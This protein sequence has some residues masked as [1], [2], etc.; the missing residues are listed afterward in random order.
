MNRFHSNETSYLPSVYPYRCVN[1]H[2]SIL[3]YGYLISYFFNC[4]RIEMCI[5]FCMWDERHLF[6][7]IISYSICN[8]SWTLFPTCCI[9]QFTI[10]GYIVCWDTL[11][12][13]IFSSQFREKLRLSEW[14]QIFVH[15]SLS[16]SIFPNQVFT[17]HNCYCDYFHNILELHNISKYETLENVCNH[18]DYMGN[19]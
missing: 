2:V 15:W 16:P 1:P 18:E 9:L 6:I 8:L 12:F 13:K 5:F 14:T 17:F 11:Y 7:L 19:L 3:I 4:W 10:Q